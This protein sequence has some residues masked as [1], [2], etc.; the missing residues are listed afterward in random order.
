MAKISTFHSEF[1]PANRVCKELQMAGIKP[2]AGCKFAD[3]YRINGCG[4][5]YHIHYY[6]KTEVQAQFTPALLVPPP[7]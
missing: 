2:I 4:Y 5:H 1:F 6:V 3:E 7:L